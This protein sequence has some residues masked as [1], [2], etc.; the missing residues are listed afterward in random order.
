LPENGIRLRFDGA[1]QRL[2]LIEVLDFQRVSLTYKGNELAKD[3]VTVPYKRIYQL[4]GAS[5]PGEYMPPESGKV[6]TYVVSYPGI[7]FTFP[8][9]HVAFGAEKDHVQLL[10]SNAAS[11]ATFMAIFEGPSWPEARDQ[12]FVN[13][14]SGPRTPAISSQPKDSLAPELEMA[15]TDGSGN[16]ALLRRAPAPPFDIILGQTTPQDLVTE[17]GPPDAT[18]RRNAQT[19]IEPFVDSRPRSK[20]RTLS[21]TNGR[22]RPTPPS[23]YSSTGTDTFDTDFDSGDADDDPA[24][25]SSRETYW[26]YFHH[27]IDI[28]VGPPSNDTTTATT[29][30][31]TNNTN[32]GALPI[33]PLITSPHLVVRK[34]I[35]HGNVP[36]SYVFN[37]HRRLRWTIALPSSSPS[38]NSHNDLPTSPIL[39]SESPFETALQPAL[40][41][42]YSHIRPASEMQRGKV[43]N[44]TWGDDGPSGGRTGGGPG[45]AD[46]VGG[47]VGD[48][49]F[50]L[51][52]ADRD[53]VEGSGSEQWLGNT[54]LYAFPGFTLEV[55]GSGAV[56]A[57][58]IS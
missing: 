13:V 27:G 3:G 10:G 22:H 1:E 51:P 58:T 2:R 39:T 34:L 57:L 42:A 12:L 37:R 33:T 29:G 31:D 9:Q 16:I 19:I 23:S 52:D 6:G 15:Y 5:Y 30:D 18:H 8:L 47:D 36:G 24:E 38:P 28:L 45:G 50:F 32:S 40:L 17:L 21:S 49:T 35:I 25:R 55:L 7:A 48:S 54:K 41:A 43:V 53:L 26:C 56:S 20:S 14:P 44:R 4:F 11:S 46:G